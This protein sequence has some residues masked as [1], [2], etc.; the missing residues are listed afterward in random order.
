MK[1]ELENEVN[2]KISEMHASED[3]DYEDDIIQDDED[4]PAN[5]SDDLMKEDTIK[6]D[7]I[8]EIMEEED[9][10]RDQDKFIL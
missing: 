2:K 8:N 3:E 10:L 6:T 9:K 4:T 1:D 7:K 5:K